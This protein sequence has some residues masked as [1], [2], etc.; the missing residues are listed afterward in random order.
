MSSRF[1]RSIR[2]VRDIN[3]QPL[4]TNEQNDFLSD[5]NGTVYVRTHNKYERITGLNKI[6]MRLNDLQSKV[7]NFNSEI[8]NIENLQSELKD[9]QTEVSELNIPNYDSDIEDLQSQIDGL[10]IPTDYNKQITITDW[11]DINVKNNYQASDK[12]H[13][14]PSYCVVDY[15]GFQEVYIRFGFEKLT[16]SQNVV[17]DI[18]SDLVPYKIYG[19]GITTVAKVPPKIIIST[20]GNIGIY[21]NE[22]DK[23]SDTDYVMYQA[24]WIIKEGN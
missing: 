2:N 3:K 16:E 11:Q 9:L 17:G 5:E 8:G 22:S 13:F 23:Y 19:N 18:P 10:N 4:N 1:V 24:S 12:T 15:G 21:P 7:D 6:N 14:K 20:N